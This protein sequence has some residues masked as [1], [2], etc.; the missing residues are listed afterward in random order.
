MPFFVWQELARRDQA[1]DLALAPLDFVP[2]VTLPMYH[3]L[4]HM[5]GWFAW[6][7]A[8]RAAFNLL[9]DTT[10]SMGNFEGGLAG[11][12]ARG[13]REF[14]QRLQT[15]SLE[16]AVNCDLDLQAPDGMSLHRFASVGPF[17][18]LGPRQLKLIRMCT[19]CNVCFSAAHTAAYAA[20]VADALAAYDIEHSG[21][22]SPAPSTAGRAAA[23]RRAERSARANL[24]PC[25]MCSQPTSVGLTGTD[26]HGN[27]Y[28]VVDGVLSFTN[29]VNPNPMLPPPPRDLADLSPDMTAVLTGIDHVQGEQK[30]DGAFRLG[31]AFLCGLPRVRAGSEIAHC[32]G[33]PRCYIQVTDGPGGGD[34]TMGD[35]VPGYAGAMDGAPPAAAVAATDARRHMSVRLSFVMSRGRAPAQP[36]V[37]EYFVTGLGHRY[38]YTEGGSGHSTMRTNEDDHTIPGNLWLK[39][40]AAQ[41]HCAVSRRVQVS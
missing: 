39:R 21:D 26:R 8:Q 6:A 4:R 35:V 37:I 18:Q 33:M 11:V 14:P 9:S 24:I 7:D 10:N 22:G 20:E 40:S 30:I 29:I 31:S 12:L 13:L 17:C 15:L 36:S 27:E 38:T 28:S 1:V 16:P 5:P 23:K 3:T 32:G 25:T 41:G 34:T 19:E 2:F